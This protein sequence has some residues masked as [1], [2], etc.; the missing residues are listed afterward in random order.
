MPGLVNAIVRRMVRAAFLVTAVVLVSALSASASPSATPASRAIQPF[1]YEFRVV[2]FSMTATLTYAKSAATIRYR[3]LKPSR[4][5][6]IYYL[7]PRPTNP[8]AAWTLT[9]AAPVVDV[10]ARATYSSPDPSC[11][12]SIEYRPAGNKIVQLFVQLDPP[13]GVLRR[14]SAGVGRIPLAIPDPGQDAGDPYPRPEKCGKP[15]MGEW[16]QDAVAYAPARL[17]SRPRVTATGN[18]S[19]R[20][21]DPGIE[22][23]E[24]TL[25]VVLQRMS[26]RAIDCR[27]HRG[28]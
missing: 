25:K 18:H 11:T 12:K 14:I 1:A 19:E 6:S 5:R 13:R 3:L 23:I 20:F 15:L 4:A 28:C 22:S 2:D 17:L 9:F 7:G 8:R 16:Y 10:A 27:T 21:T 26:Y 24:W